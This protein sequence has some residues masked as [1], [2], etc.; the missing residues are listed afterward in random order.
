MQVLNPGLWSYECLS[1]A[2]KL[3][4][5]SESENK[6]D[7]H[8]IVMKCILYYSMKIIYSPW[9]ARKGNTISSSLDIMASLKPRPSDSETKIHFWAMGEKHGVH[10]LNS[11]QS[12]YCMSRPVPSRPGIHRNIML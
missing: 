11:F 8:L 9:A 2:I 5:K 1:P 7:E 10:L 6:C 4:E 3:L 12:P